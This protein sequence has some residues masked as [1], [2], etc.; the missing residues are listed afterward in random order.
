M[1]VYRIL[2]DV[3]VVVHGLYVSFVVLGLL[4]VLA[5]RACGWQWTQNR[6]FR[7][8][9]LLAIAAVVVQA[10]LGVV[11]PLTILENHFRERAGEAVYPGS[12][13]GY[14]AHELLFIEAPPWVFTLAYTL[15]GIVVLAGLLLAPP[16][17]TRGEGLKH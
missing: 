3:V 13:I 17:W 14:W 2:A 1:L 4:A 16:K 12:F 7:G 6:W 9:H 8:V 5:G 10:W 15:F 11:C